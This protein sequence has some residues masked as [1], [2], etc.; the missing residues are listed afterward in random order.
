MFTGI[1]WGDYFIGAAITLGCYYFIVIICCYRKEISG[2]FTGNRNSASQS[3]KIKPEDSVE[4]LEQMVSGINGIL[5]AAG[6]EAGKSELLT[7]LKERL[8]SFA[9]LRQPAYRVALTNYII[10]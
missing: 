2:L 3:S 6:K 4:E 10:K 7:G 8:A 1:S 9:G 5:V